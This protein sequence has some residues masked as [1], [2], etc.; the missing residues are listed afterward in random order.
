MPEHNTIL[1]CGQMEHYGV[2]V[3][4]KSMKI[5]GGKQ[6]ILTPEGYIIPMDFHDGLAYIKMRPY[7][8]S[9]W[10][11]LPHVMLVSQNEWNPSVMDYDATNDKGFFDKLS[12]P[13]IDYKDHPFDLEGNHKDVN[14]RSLY[15][16]DTYR[17]QEEF[18]GSAV[19]LP[20]IAVNKLW[21][22]VPMMEILC[23]M[24]ARIYCHTTFLQ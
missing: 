23:A 7:T 3:N 5:S 21:S 8:D 24:T 10:D 11:E 9:E 22:T 19:T 15:F 6:R 12:E 13:D 16:L 20:L 17:A 14:D 1:S 4:D 2:D 18:I